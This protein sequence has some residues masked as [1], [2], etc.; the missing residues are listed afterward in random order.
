[1]SL[2]I[3][4]L[5][6]QLIVILIPIVFIVLIVLL[7]RSSIKRNEQLKRIEEK[8]DKVTEMPKS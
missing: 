4:D 5:I 8:L 1:M 6:F 2:N 3:G 7:V